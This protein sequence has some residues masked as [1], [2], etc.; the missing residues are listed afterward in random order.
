MGPPSSATWH[1]QRLADLQCRELSLI[2]PIHVVN[3]E[4]EDSPD[5]AER[6]ADQIL[7]FC[8][9]VRLRRRPTATRCQ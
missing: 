3:V 9:D 5:E 6:A 2:K 4:V 8:L 1:S 7:G